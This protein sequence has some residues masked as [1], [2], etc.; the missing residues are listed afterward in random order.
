V[1]HFSFRL[2][3]RNHLKGLRYALSQI[4]KMA[5]LTQARW[6]SW[7]LLRRAE[8]ASREGDALPRPSFRGCLFGS[9]LLHRA[10][11]PDKQ[12]A[13]SR[14][15]P[16]CEA[17][18]GGLLMRSRC[19]PCRCRCNPSEFQRL[20]VALPC[21]SAPLGAGTRVP[22]LGLQRSPPTTKV[23]T[24]SPCEQGEHRRPRGSMEDGGS[25]SRAVPPSTPPATGAARGLCSAL[26]P[27][28]ARL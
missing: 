25:S 19:K 5:G 23:H 4:A 17:C 20:L 9:S 26:N 7:P 27:R 10:P 8:S 14:S 16:P 12:A 3:Q 21:Y 1:R 6:P 24:V 22:I 11:P 15:R 28:A 13:A 18:Q 2:T